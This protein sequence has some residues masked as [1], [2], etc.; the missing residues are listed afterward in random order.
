MRKPY[1]VARA[2]ASKAGIAR[3]APTYHARKLVE[4]APRLTPEERAHVSGLL[5]VLLDADSGGG[6]G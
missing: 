6:N 2:C 3:T 5:S 1:E 4:A